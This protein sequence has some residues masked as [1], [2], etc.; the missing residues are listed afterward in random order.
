M[1]APGATARLHAHASAG[2]PNAPLSVAMLEI[3]SWRRVVLVLAA[4][5]VVCCT[6]GPSQSSQG[7]DCPGQ[8]PAPA[9]SRTYT[10][11]GT[12]GSQCTEW[13]CDDGWGDCGGGAC[14]ADLTSDSSQCG[15]CGNACANGSPCSTG[16]CQPIA[17]L[18]DGLNGPGPVVVDGDYV[19]FTDDDGIHTTLERVPAAGGDVDVLATVDG[20][21]ASL[22]HDITGLYCMSQCGVVYASRPP[23]T[24]AIAVA[25]AGTFASGLALGGGWVWWTDSGSDAPD[26]SLGIGPPGDIVRVRESG[27]DQQIV[28]SLPDWYLGASVAVSGGD[29]FAGAGYTV[30]VV[31]SGSSSSI[32]LATDTLL[33]SGIA[34]DDTFVYWSA[35]GDSSCSFF[36]D[37]PPPPP[38]TALRRVPRA[39]GAVQTLATAGLSLLVAADGSAWGTVTGKGGDVLVRIDG[40]GTRTVLA[41]AQGRIEGVAVDGLSVYWTAAFGKGKGK[42]LSTG[43]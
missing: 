22:A 34:V 43:R 38:P 26:A 7:C 35:T 20:L 11:S 18:V 39:G 1:V 2:T 3:S 24:D 13:T 19:W 5:G 28:A 29:T 36:C 16:S 21:C 30:V 12:A 31:R 15:D 37:T 33:V 23:D 27:L 41:G 14:S 17:T 9:H 25:T 6:L 42:V 32:T 8:G 10:A 4:G 40:D